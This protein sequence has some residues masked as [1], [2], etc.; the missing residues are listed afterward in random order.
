MEFFI[1]H[2]KYKN[3][4]QRKTDKD[5]CVRKD[6]KGLNVLPTS[7]GTQLSFFYIF[8]FQQAGKTAYRKVHDHSNYEFNTARLSM[9]LLETNEN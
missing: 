5:L 9:S 6:R 2:K 4:Q 7:F 8:F 3:L 1:V